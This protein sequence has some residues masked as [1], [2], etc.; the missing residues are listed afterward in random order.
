MNYFK[1][2][3]EFLERYLST[4]PELKKMRPQ[5]AYEFEPLGGQVKFDEVWTEK[6]FQVLD[7]EIGVKAQNAYLQDMSDIKVYFMNR[8]IDLAKTGLVTKEEIRKVAGI[9]ST[10]KA[11][12]QLAAGS[13]SFRCKAEQYERY[14]DGTYHNPYDLNSICRA[15]MNLLLTLT[16]TVVELDKKFSEALTKILLG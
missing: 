7:A 12:D 15:R 1:K 2:T 9:K 3:R 5:E 11:L 4:N 10:L 8:L 16:D 13:D 14:D 6:D